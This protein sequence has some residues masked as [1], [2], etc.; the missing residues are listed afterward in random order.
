MTIQRT[1]PSLVSGL[2]PIDRTLRVL[3]GAARARPRWSSCAADDRVT[4]IDPDGGQPAEL[5]VL[6]PDGRDDPGALGAADAPATVLREL[7]ATATTASSA[8]STRAGCARTTRWRC[9]CSGR[10]LA[11]RS[12]S[13]A[14]SATRCSWSPPRAAAWS[15]ATRR[16]PRS[17]SR[18][19][20][21]RRA[22]EVEV[23]AAGAAGRAAARLPRATG[24]RALAYEVREG[25]YI[26]IIDVQGA[27]A[28]TSSP[29]TSTSSRAGSS[30]ASTA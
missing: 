4:V 15:T 9:V 2:K 16:R 21:P 24:R 13:F 23:G 12:Q 25:E 17:W 6:S 5:T 19:S 1:P 7:V 18:S 26:Q 30:A 10:R 28:R 27:S 11:R 29:S 8:R 22:R 3:V 20:G 14:S